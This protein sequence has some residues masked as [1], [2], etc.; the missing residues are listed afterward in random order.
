MFGRKLLSVAAVAGVLTIS[1]AAFSGGT[2]DVTLLHFDEASEV[3]IAIDGNNGIGQFQHGA[4]TS[5]LP[6]LIA[7]IHQ[8]PPNPCVPLTRL[9]NKE[10]E[11]QDGSVRQRR[12][13]AITMTLLSRARCTAVIEG[14]SGGNLSSFQPRN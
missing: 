5:H 14:V 7:N 10:L 11:R 9:Y 6:G 1:G 13:L 8:L 3:L 4:F 2:S 12:M